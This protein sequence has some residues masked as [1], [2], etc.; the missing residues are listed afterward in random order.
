MIDQ[1]NKGI[2]NVAAC[3]HL[4]LSLHRCALAGH[5]LIGAC[6]VIGS[7]CMDLASQAIRPTPPLIDTIAL[8]NDAAGVVSDLLA[9]RLV[10]VALVISGGAAQLGAALDEAG[11]PSLEETRRCLEEGVALDNAP[12]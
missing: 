10:N 9:Q 12:S 4:A 8:F 1:N 7:A 5:S 6:C 3:K 2:D 11:V